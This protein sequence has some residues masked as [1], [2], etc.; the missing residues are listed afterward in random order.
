MLPIMLDLSFGAVILVGGGKAALRRLRL[1]EESGAGDIRVYP[2]EDAMPEL[3]EAAG[4][5]ACKGL[6]DVAA[7]RAARALFV[8]EAP[9]AAALAATAREFG[10]LVNVEDVKALCDFYTPSVVRRG[11]LAIA[12]STEGASPGLARRIRQKIESLFGLEWGPKLDALAA[13]RAGWQAQG[14]DM[15]AITART[16]EWIERNGGL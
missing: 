15:A 6:P 2:G 5:R 14:L 9:E 4:A 13:L 12:I 16:D 3:C 1:L 11:R 7:I 10:V 8:A